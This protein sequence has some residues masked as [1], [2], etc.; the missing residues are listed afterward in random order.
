MSGNFASSTPCTTARFEAKLDDVHDYTRPS[1]QFQQAIGAAWVGLRRDSPLT[2]TNLKERTGGAVSS[3]VVDDMVKSGVL[4]EMRGALLPSDEWCDYGDARKL[5][6]VLVGGGGVPLVDVHSGETIAEVSR[7]ADAQGTLYAGGGLRVVHGADDRG[8]YVGI[9]QGASTSRLVRL[10]SA[11][12]RFRGLSRQVMWSMARSEGHD[13]ARWTRDGGR[14]CTWGGAAY[15]L[16]LKGILVTTGQ[17]KK[18]RHD[19]LAIDGLTEDVDVTPESARRLARAM[20]EAGGIPDVFAKRFREPTQ[21]LHALSP[22]MAREE[23]K[24]SVPRRGFIEWLAKVLSLKVVPAPTGP[25]VDG[26]N[27]AICGHLKRG[28]FRRPETGVVSI[29]FTAFSVGKVVR[30]LVRQL[31]GPHLSTC[32]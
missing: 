31:R 7:G 30:T 8:V 6:S 24:R 25:S 9:E 28:H 18:L 27:P 12:G 14:L 15:N 20:F 32:A 23:A 5:H 26:S 11:R 4:R 29:Y 21:F 1:V 10:P 22:A 2:P 17:P 19:D 3:D 16:L 13:P